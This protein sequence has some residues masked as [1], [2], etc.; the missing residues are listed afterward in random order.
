M[1]TRKNWIFGHFSRNYGRYSIVLRH[2]LRVYSLL[3]F[4]LEKNIFAFTTLV[5]QSQVNM[6]DRRLSFK[7]FLISKTV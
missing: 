1:R 6:C 4:L 2:T 3:H 7:F 5:S